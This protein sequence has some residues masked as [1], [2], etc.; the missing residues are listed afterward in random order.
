[1][2]CK[3]CILCVGD[4]T[5]TIL[6]K[7]KSDVWGWCVACICGSSVSRRSACQTTSS[8]HVGVMEVYNTSRCALLFIN[9]MLTMV[10]ADWWQV[11]VFWGENKSAFCTYV[12]GLDS[13]HT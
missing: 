9:D 1:M 5:V 4:W 6:S 12:R 8:S 13:F 2:Y 7:R 11:F 3:I 10:Q